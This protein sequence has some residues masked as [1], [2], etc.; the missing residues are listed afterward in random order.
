MRG[1]RNYDSE[2]LQYALRCG[3]STLMTTEPMWVGRKTSLLRL[4]RIQLFGSSSRARIESKVALAAFKGALPNPD[5]T[6][7]AY[8][9]TPDGG[10]APS[11]QVR[12]S[13]LG[14]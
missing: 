14:Y 13:G 3:A 7:R 11:A 2:L 4:P 6:G 1:R 12:L 8:C 10:R 9:F 5:G